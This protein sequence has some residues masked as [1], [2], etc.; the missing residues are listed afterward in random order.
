MSKVEITKADGTIETVSGSMNDK[1]FAHLGPAR[2]WV[3]YKIV[4]DGIIPEMSEKEKELKAYYD[5][6]DKIVHA[7][8]YGY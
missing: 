6:H 4:D 7:Q 1:L 5:G 8:K 3:S 2:G